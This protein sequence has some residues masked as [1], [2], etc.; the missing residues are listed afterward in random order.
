M[1]KG[2]KKSKRGKI[3]K[4]TYGVSRSRKAIKARLKRTQTAGK[5]VATEAEAVSPV[6]K[7]RKTMRK[8]AAE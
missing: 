8:K 3:W 6:R 7:A 2:D 4:G 1:G 5:A